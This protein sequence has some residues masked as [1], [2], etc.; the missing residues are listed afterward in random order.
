MNRYIYRGTK[1]LRCGYTTGSC[2]AG[3]AKAAA[4]YLLGGQPPAA[5]TLMPPAGIPLT[6][7][8]LAPQ[9]AGDTASCA[10]RKDSGDD[11]DIT[12]GICIYA[13][14]SKCDAGIIIEGGKGIGTV[15]KPGLNQ[16]VGASA[17]N[18]TPRRMI[19]EALTEIAQKYGYTGGF[20]VVISAP[21]GEEL[22]KKPSIPHGHCRRYFDHRDNR[23]C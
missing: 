10:V 9:L 6:L 18:D 4:E 13:A 20:R 5:V 17:I 8:V 7:D 16:P 14:V 23:D 1:K 15:T 22:A 21:D 11:P 2:A 19:R 3:A 12:N